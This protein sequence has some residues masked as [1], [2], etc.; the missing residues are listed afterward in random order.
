MKTRFLER[1]RIRDRSGLIKGPFQRSEVIEHIR[2]RKVDGEE[3]IFLESEGKWKPIAADTQ[4]FDLIQEV[5]FGIKAETQSGASTKGV[6][7]SSF[8]EEKNREVD[9]TER[10]GTAQKSQMTTPTEIRTTKSAPL[11]E[12]QTE[13]LLAVAEQKKIK[14]ASQIKGHE[15]KASLS[16]KIETKSPS[17]SSGEPV[18]EITGFEQ[19]VDKKKNKKNFKGAPVFLLLGAIALLGIYFLPDEKGSNV[20]LANV[21]FEF[22]FQKGYFRPLLLRLRLLNG[23]ELPPK[24]LNNDISTIKVLPINLHDLMLKEEEFSRNLNLRDNA[25]TWIYKSWT[26]RL[27]GDV[28]SAADLK[29]GKEFRDV[30][31][32][33][34]FQLE[35]Q[36]LLNS[37]LKSLFTSL[38][39]LID[40]EVG[41]AFDVLKT[42]KE[43]SLV[44]EIYIRELSYWAT[45]GGA[46]ASSAPLS[47]D[48][49]SELSLKYQFEEELRQKV[50]KN[51]FGSGFLTAAE[52]ALAQDSHSLLSWFLISRYY[53]EKYQGG[54]AVPNRYFFTGLCQLSLWPRSL[55]A[56][57]WRVYAQFLEKT[58]SKDAS[59]L[60]TSADL[61]EVGA[62][63]KN[64]VSVD[65]DD[66]LFG[67][68]S[69]LANYRKAFQENEMNPIEL[70]SFEV[71][72][73]ASPDAKENLVAVL[74]SP[75]LDKNW[76]LAD[77]RL[78][79]IE[80]TFP[81]DSNVKTLR[82]WLEA[83]RFR[84]ERAQDLL[85][86]SFGSA[87][88]NDYLRAEGILYIL[89][90]DYEG[91]SEILK[92]YLET[93]QQD[94][95]SYFFLS[96]AALENEKYTDCVK[97]SKFSM[98]NSTGPLR[99]R[100]QTMNYRCRVLAQLGVDDA[101]RDFS[102]FVSQ[103]PYNSIS[104]EEYIRALMDAGRSQE[105]VKISEKN[106]REHPESASL[107][108]LLGEVYEARGELNEA[109]A[110]YNEARRIDSKNV[111]AAIHIADLFFKD[112]RYKEAAQ[113]YVAAGAQ[114]LELP[115][116]FLKAARAY[117]KAGNYNEA[118][119]MYFKEIDLRPAVLDTF[120]E[121]AE[122]MLESN[123]PS[124][125]PDLFAHFSENFRSD[126]R[127]LT[128]LAQAYFAMG[129]K[130]NA[131][132]NAELA[133]RQGPTEA[134]PYRI[135]GSI[136][137]ADGQYP[138][139]KANYEKYLVLLPQAPE[140]AALKQK[141][142]QPPFAY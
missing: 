84:F 101:L 123:R 8:E 139:A 17:P 99:L 113:N 108:I 15:K 119:K 141:L 126:S 115:E 35:S 104:R 60:S 103:F 129:D 88:G 28:V 2:N 74:I 22:K 9:K 116:L 102:Q 64:E 44:A 27:L 112:R 23:L 10:L 31:D 82:L 90:R 56:M 77:R 37:E 53:A 121:A 100:S 62:Y 70:A 135:L 128:R 36:G 132:L 1:I 136:F 131:R 26:Y 57:Y 76:S 49:L 50:T 21:S 137:E 81:F 87:N 38:D 52:N 107:K 111:K 85:Q 127:V 55:Q 18:K 12:S 94:A 138:L 109:L 67:Y 19:L 20:N 11:S 4:F 125:V 3:E 98:L 133:A 95:I 75:L 63:D 46:D 13:E 68:A 29:K 30:S 110:L 140:A 42:I 16:P 91:G 106:V 78:R 54:P 59:R 79:M 69:L 6:W 130:K 58:G 47:Y 97:Y 71:L 66:P 114:D 134:E 61:I 25:S 83:E 142:S 105:A 72:S 45:L 40:G 73:E 43:P 124:G 117:R 86:N 96:R 14:E 65:I 93:N 33:I 5:L 122:F 118:Q 24:K 34:L 48:E 51:D 80:K 41:K 32:T 39:Y 7:T 92:K 89:A 120:L